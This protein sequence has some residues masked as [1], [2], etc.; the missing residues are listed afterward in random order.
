MCPSHDTMIAT[1]AAL[2]CRAVCLAEILSSIVS[3]ACTLAKSQHTHS[4][5]LGVMY[6]WQPVCT[7]T[8]DAE[9]DSAMSSYLPAMSLTFEYVIDGSAT[10][11]DTIEMTSTIEITIK[12]KH[13]K[14]R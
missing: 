7:A 11:R 12:Q 2:P 4:G 9:C 10:A 6:T 5:T 1:R 14:D 13:A 8:G 3:I